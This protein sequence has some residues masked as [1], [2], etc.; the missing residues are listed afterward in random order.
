[1]ARGPKLCSK[2][3]VSTKLDRSFNIDAPPEK[4]CRAMRNP[5]LIEESER[6]RD[7]LSVKITQREETEGRHQYEVL[8]MSP[9]RTVKGID[10]TKSEE[11]RTVV[12]WDLPRLAATWSWTGVHGP[13]VKIDGGYELRAAGAGASLRM[14]AEIDIGLPLVG[15]MIEKKV[16]EGFETAWPDYVARVTKY[17]KL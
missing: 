6:A 10:K 15:G 1:M 16:K 9:A 4:V 3:T 2:G 17:A 12:T 8:V 5:A 13:K 7:A 11:N 14:W